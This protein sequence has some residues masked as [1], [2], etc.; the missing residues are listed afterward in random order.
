[1]INSL[2]FIIPTVVLGLGFLPFSANAGGQTVIPS[3]RAAVQPMKP[4]A[5]PA[6]YRQRCVKWRRHCRVFRGC[7]GGWRHR[8]FYRTRVVYTP[9]GPEYMRG[10]W[11]GRFF[12]GCRYWETFRRCYVSCVRWR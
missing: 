1:M 9:Y 4:F 7:V 5:Q 10:R 12:R 8:C 3:E 2:K 6:G 11:C